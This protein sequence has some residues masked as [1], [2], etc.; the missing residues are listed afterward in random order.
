MF[1]CIKQKLFDEKKGVSE[2]K[3]C[4]KTQGNYGTYDYDGNI[5][6][7]EMQNNIMW[8]QQTTQDSIC[9]SKMYNTCRSIEMIKM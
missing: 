6:T 9:S 3:G 5:C 7:T 2:N 4:P 1:L 8:M